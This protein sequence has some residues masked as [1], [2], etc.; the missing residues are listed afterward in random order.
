MAARA[1]SST[2]KPA[3]PAAGRTNTLGI[4][5]RQLEAIAQLFDP[6][7]GSKEAS[8]RREFVRWGF[9][10]VSIPMQVVHPGGSRVT[11]RV[12]CYNLSAGGMG[13]LH[14]TFMYPGSTC[15]VSLP[16]PKK[17]DT[18]VTA[19]V[20]R[21]R[22]VHR[23]IHDVGIRFD[24]AIDARE[25]LTEDASGA[26]RYALEHVRPES[27]QGTLVYIEELEPEH[28]LLQHYLRGT[29]LRLRV[30]R[31]SD[32]GAQLIREGCDLVLCN[33]HLIKDKAKDI[34]EA[35]SEAGV[36]CLAV[37]SAGD[38]VIR[39][40]DAARRLGFTDVL[41]RPFAHDGLLRVLGEY[42]LIRRHAPDPAESTA[43]EATANM[44]DGFLRS[45]PDQL[46]RLSGTIE[47]RDSMAAFLLCL[48]LKGVAT[49]L[50]LGS[51]A[52]LANAASES[53]AA[54]MS[55]EESLQQVNELVRACQ[56]EI[57]SAG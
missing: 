52:K 18:W 31:S 43:D 15:K 50:G 40:P 54:T 1:P 11:F 4:N 22:H 56:R 53:L 36:A 21:C 5:Q 32:Q 44:R 38:T 42:L 6:Y 10:N 29:S 37:V 14:S 45:L 46:K 34:L 13:V 23:M 26:S 3:E 48:Q 7:H 33:Y 47:Q 27:L 35:V 17:G 41:N 39:T 9:R 55:V 8:K 30:A 16:H 51:I 28:M 24:E 20:A 19:K 12:A 49:P 25:Y 57:A 2:K